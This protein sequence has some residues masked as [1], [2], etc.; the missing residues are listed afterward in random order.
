MGITKASQSEQ[1]I[2][3]TP[4]EITHRASIIIAIVEVLTVQLRT[5][6]TNPRLVAFPAYIIM[7]M[8]HSIS[9]SSPYKPYYLAIGHTF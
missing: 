9:F 2:A 7:N 4:Y 1:I 8:V 5:T 6:I 3:K